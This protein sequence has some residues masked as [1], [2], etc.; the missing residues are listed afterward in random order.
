MLF[1]SQVD[2]EFP[3]GTVNI[4]F[5]EK[6]EPVFNVIPDVAFDHIEFSPEALKLV[7]NADCLFYGL[8]PQRFGISKNTIRELIKESSGSIK[9]FDLKL[10]QHFFNTEVVKQLLQ[11]AHIVRIKEKEIEFL[12]EKLGLTKGRLHDFGEQLANTYQIDLVLITRGSNGI[13]AFHKTQG[14]YFDSGY[15]IDVKD[16]IGSGMAFS[17]GFLHFYMNGKMLGES[18]NFGNAAGALN[19]TKVG[20]TSFFTKHEVLKFMKKNKKRNLELA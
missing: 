8:L 18:V 3:T 4:T 2:S 15:Q 13:F 20:A 10:F 17:A 19:A 16:N 5:D 11:S 9:F 7:R 6:H 1:R 12:S 14:E